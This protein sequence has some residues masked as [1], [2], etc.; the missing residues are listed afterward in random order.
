MVLKEKIWPLVRK[1]L[2]E[3]NLNIYGAYCDEKLNSLYSEKDGF[4]VKGR[5][6]HVA[7]V[8]KNAKVCLAPVLFGAGLKGKLLEAMAA[9]TPSVTTSIGA[10]GIENSNNWPGF[11]SDDFVEFAEKACQLYTDFRYWTQSVQT[12][13]KILETNFSRG[14]FEPNFFE[15]LRY[16]EFNLSSHRQENFYGQILQHHTLA[17]TKYLS[18]YIMAKNKKSE[19][20][21]D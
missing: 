15:L 6:A 1:K 9:G 2:P 13:K 10:E 12:G 18:K 4:K 14:K 19:D 17:S 11:V 5:A 8:M 3:A 7:Q 20:Q 16:L 21:T